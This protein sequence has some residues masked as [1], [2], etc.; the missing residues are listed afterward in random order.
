MRTLEAPDR[1]AR[2]VPQCRQHFGEVAGRDDD[3]RNNS[4]RAGAQPEL[5]SAKSR[6]V[7]GHQQHLGDRRRVPAAVAHERIAVEQ[8]TVRPRM[9]S[10]STSLAVC[11]LAGGCPRTRCCEAVRSETDLGSSMGSARTSSLAAPT[12]QHPNEATNARHVALSCESP[13]NEIQWDARKCEYS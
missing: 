3:A 13:I 8:L 5:S 2:K 11:S 10:V 6:K 9:L 7:D 12:T 4:D 1:L